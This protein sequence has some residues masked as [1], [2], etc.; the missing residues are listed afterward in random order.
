ML[1]LVYI[2]AYA[3][4]VKLFRRTAMQRSGCDPD[5][6]LGLTYFISPFVKRR[7]IL[8]EIGRAFGVE[9]GSGA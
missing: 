9:V 1:L 2:G 5:F 6:A 8:T 7:L 4:I 3:R